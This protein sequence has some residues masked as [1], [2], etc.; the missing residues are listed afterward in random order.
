[1]YLDE[2][3]FA[4]ILKHQIS[5]LSVTAA[6]ENTTES[7]MNLVT[8]VYASIFAMLTSLTH[9]DFFTSD[10]SL[11]KPPRLSDFPSTTCNSSSIVYLRV[12]VNTLDDCLCLL[13][14]RLSQLHTFI[15]KIDETENSSITIDNT[16][17][18]SIICIYWH[19]L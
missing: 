2:S 11:Y 15:V 13:D 9:L 3:S 14:G 8:H 7:M 10:D 12:R 16:V 6:E 18:K 4:Q 19:I 1:V 5:H 17:N